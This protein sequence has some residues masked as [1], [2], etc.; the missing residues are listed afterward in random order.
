MPN[1]FFDHTKGLKDQ[2]L[3]V[4]KEGLDSMDYED[5]LTSILQTLYDLVGRPVIQRLQELNIPEQSCIWWC[6]TS[7]FC[8]LPLHA[9]GPIQ[10]D[11]TLKLYFF[12]TR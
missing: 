5:T 3:A 1:D 2:L 9:M 12:V 11:G 6:P 10:S 8:S 7:V 4:R